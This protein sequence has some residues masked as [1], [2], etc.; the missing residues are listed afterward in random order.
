MLTFRWYFGIHY[1]S[2]LAKLDRTWFVS[3]IEHNEEH[4]EHEKRQRDEDQPE[5]CHSSI[6]TKK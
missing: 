4:D 3:R 1:H 2:I 6:E 5:G